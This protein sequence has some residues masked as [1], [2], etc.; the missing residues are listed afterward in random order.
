[1]ITVVCWK[2]KSPRG[3]RSTFTSVHVN[4][5]RNMVARHLHLPHEFVCVT[6]DPEG[7]NKDIH[8]VRLWDDFKE[9]QS[10]VGPKRPSCYCR[11]KVFNAE[12]AGLGE[13]ILSIDLDAVITGDITPLVSRD[14]DFV[15]WGDTTPRTLYNGS[16]WLLRRGTRQ[17]VWDEF[18]PAKSP[19]LTKQARIIGSDQAWI[20]YVLGSG[21]AT[22]TKEDG[23]YS[24]R[25]NLQGN[26]YS[27]LPSNVRIVFFHGHRDPWHSDIQRKY[28][29]VRKNYR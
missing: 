10:F 27:T 19:Q 18:D 14:E 29:W 4:T 11:L 8:L 17:R 13:R 16:F 1:M 28:T 25:N 12:A 26:S 15:I 3:Y 20:S 2:W 23:V 22:W 21:E 24:F 5:L 9:L 7:I 6:D